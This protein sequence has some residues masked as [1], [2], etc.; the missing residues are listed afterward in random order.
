MGVLGT[1]L[2]RA[3]LNNTYT[4]DYDVNSGRCGC[5]IKAKDPTFFCIHSQYS[6]FQT[7]TES[8]T[9]RPVTNDE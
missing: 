6:L 9:H 1:D 7:A 2:K 3:N 8:G 5:S 4:H